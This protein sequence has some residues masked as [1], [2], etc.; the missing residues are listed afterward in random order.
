MAST[1][2]YNVIGYQFV[3][4]AILLD[5]LAIIA[6]EDQA[7]GAALAFDDGVRRQSSRESREFYVGRVRSAWVLEYGVNS[8]ANAQ[9]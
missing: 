9:R 2:D 1:Q 6:N 4:K 3:L 8:R 7:H 5:Q